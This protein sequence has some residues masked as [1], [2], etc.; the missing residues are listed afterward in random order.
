M[1]TYVVSARQFSAAILATSLFS[2]A[3]VCA[4][5]L[6][7]S[8][9]ELPEVHYSDNGCT[10]VVNFK[11]GDAYQCADVDVTLRKYRKIKD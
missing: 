1:A 9:R 3:C 4:G 11:N 10:R 7:L 2:T 5:M 8:Y 6:Y